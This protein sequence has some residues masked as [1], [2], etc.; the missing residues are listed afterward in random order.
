MAE[1]LKKPRSIRIVGEVPR[2]VEPVLEREHE[3]KQPKYLVAKMRAFADGLQP[4]LRETYYKNLLRSVDVPQSI[5]RHL[6]F[7][8]GRHYVEQKKPD[9]AL[10]AF[11]DSED[12]RRGA[13]ILAKAG[14]HKQAAQLYEQAKAFYEA[15]FHYRA[16]GFE[17]HAGHLL[18]VAEEARNRK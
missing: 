1:W 2:R 10:K 4:D 14:F 15:A 8:L 3:I 17:K 7:L 11:A 18:R 12:R 16:A 5:K 9:F 6:Q 13:Q